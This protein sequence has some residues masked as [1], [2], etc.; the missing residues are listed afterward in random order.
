MKTELRGLIN[1]THTLHRLAGKV[2][3]EN[4]FVILVMPARGINNDEH[5]VEK[6]KEFLD[7]FQKHNAVNMGGMKA[8]HLYD[9]TL[10]Q[11]KNKLYHELPMIHGVF[12]NRED[13]VAA[14]KEI[15]A[16]DM[17]ISVIVT[18]LIDDVDGC[19]KDAG[20]KRHS[21]NYS[22]GM[23]GNLDKIEDERYLEL[24]TMCGHAMV[25]VNLVKKMIDDIKRGRI[26]ID[27]AAAE[28]AMPCVCGI[29]NTEK[30]KKVLKELM[31]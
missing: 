22:L 28:L 19:C 2:G 31:D 16:E 26:T 21:V 13:L 1:M 20:L 25:S 15:K 27:K 30:A 14:L 4:D 6:Y 24:T 12:S 10:E 11:I 5:V 18:G 7:I 17:G 9:S 23:W 29:F 8:G 3:S